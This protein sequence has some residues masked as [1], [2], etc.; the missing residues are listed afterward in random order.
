MRLKQ[1]ILTESLTFK[2]GNIP[3]STFA[4]IKKDCKPFLKD[5]KHTNGTFLFRGLGIYTDFF[6]KKPRKDRKPL[7]SNPKWHD[8]LDMALKNKF[9]TKIRSEGVFCKIMT[10]T[11]YGIDY[12]ILPK[13]PYYCVWNPAI[14]DAYFQEPS[15]GRDTTVEELMDYANN[16]AKGYIKGSLR[17][18]V[19]SLYPQS[20]NYEIALICKEY[21]A[22]E[23]KHY[24]QFLEWINNEI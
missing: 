22:L 7:D 8:A 14:S 17:D 4:L 1:H 15:I 20:K 5:A 24:E 3:E 21:H 9:G 2:K 10:P 13:G 12:I 19:K 11:G 16:A 18:V 23:V 6:T